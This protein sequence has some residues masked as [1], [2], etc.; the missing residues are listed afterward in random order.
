MNKLL[1]YSALAVVMGAGASA[2]AVAD[3]ASTKG[4]VVIKSDDGQFEASLGGRLHYDYNYIDEDEV[5][6]TSTD[7]FFMRR[8]YITLAGKLYG[9]EYKLETDIKGND[10]AAKDMWIGYKTLGGFVKAGHMQPAY[11]MEELTSSNDILFIERPFLSN[12]TVFSGREY[13]NGISYDT[14]GEQYSA[15]F[16]YYNANAS[17]DSD[18]S[19]AA[20]G[21]GMSGRVTFAPI[22]TKTSLVHVGASYDWVDFDDAI[23][24]PSPS[25]SARYADRNG[26]RLTI[27]SGGYGQQSTATVEAAAMYGPFSVQGEYGMATYE[28]KDADDQDVDAWYVQA[29]WFVTG[30][31]RTYKV[32]RGVFGSVKPNAPTGAWEL[33]ARYDTVKNKDAANDPEATTISAGVNYYMNPAVR[34]MLDYNFG[35]AEQTG[36]PDDEPSAIALRAQLKF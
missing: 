27:V 31:S 36:A 14:A 33:K 10:P 29:S 4:G 23:A 22:N 32:E 2:P 5:E 17:A 3:T 24:N 16:A 20:E 15:F 25:A 7:G 35:S 9:F 12:N 11:G 1:G 6:D 28:T 21:D 30:E 26:P 18:A 13:Q 19:R 8:A 34:F